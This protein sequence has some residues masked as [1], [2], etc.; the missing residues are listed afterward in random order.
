MSED[1][2]HC[3]ADWIACRVNLDFGLGANDHD[4]VRVSDSG[5]MRF[6]FY[7]YWLLIDRSKHLFA[8]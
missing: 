6:G 3:K 1:D 4:L 2:H 7:C 5:Q 8:C